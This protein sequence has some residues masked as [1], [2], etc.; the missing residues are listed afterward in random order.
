M[1]LHRMYAIAIISNWCYCIDLRNEDLKLLLMD[2]RG[3]L[4]H[5]ILLRVFELC[6]SMRL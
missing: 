5:L 3:Q 2:K 6:V 4:L 1:G